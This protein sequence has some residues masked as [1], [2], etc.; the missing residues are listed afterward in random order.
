MPFATNGG[1]RLF[2][3]LEG[4]AERPVLLLLS[5]LGADLSLW[6]RVA[7]L[8]LRRF[9]LLRMDARGHGASDTPPGDYHLPDLAADALAVMDASGTQQAAVCGIAFGGAI[10]LT[11][12][13]NAPARVA[14]VICACSSAQVRSEAWAEQVRRVRIAGMAGVAERAMTE[15]FSESFVRSHPEVVDSVRTTLRLTDPGGYAGGAA[16]LRDMALLEQLPAVGQPVLLLSGTRD[17]VTPFEPHGARLLAALP[18]ARHVSLDAAHLTCVE[19][20]EAFAVALGQFLQS[21]ELSAV[22]RDADQSD[23]AGSN[24]QRLDEAATALY[25]AGLRIRREVLGDAWVERALASRTDFNR[26]FQ[27]MITRSAWQEIWSRPGLDRRTR[28]LLVLALTV[29]QG[30]WE[31]FRLHVR[32]GL[33]NAGFSET[34]L[35]EVLMQ[36]AVYAGVPAANTAFAQA[37]EVMRELQAP[38]GPSAR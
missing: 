28:R 25:D 38:G 14:A 4:A 10:A 31:E 27:E 26:D 3:R 9:R 17:V 34:E 20:P 19:A 7:P 6:D 8:L 23:A 12:A 33:A 29:A 16:A 15:F 35:R 2:W 37:A 13:L 5:S 30:R 32:A 22:Q 24:A 1:V 11:L 18:N 21:L 36:S